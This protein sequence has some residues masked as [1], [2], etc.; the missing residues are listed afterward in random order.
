MKL[1]RITL[2]PLLFPIAIV[3]GIVL[4]IRNRFY[5]WGILKSSEFEIP[6]ISV[7]NITVGGTGKT[8]HIEYLI[9]LLK[10]EYQIAALS[11]G[12]KRKTDGFIL[13][14][15]ESTDL[16]IGDE[17]RQIKQK[18]PEVNIAVDANR[19]EGINKLIRLKPE[20]EAILL[21]DA[22]QHRKVNPGLSILLTDYSRPIFK[23]FMLP[24]GNLRDNY[25]EKKRADV[26]IVTKCPKDLNSKKQNQI[27]ERLKL[28]PS[29]SIFFSTF[30]YGELIPVFSD[31]EKSNSITSKDIEILMVSGIANPTPLKEHILENISENIRVL[32][33][34]DHYSFKPSDFKHI[35]QTFNKI[36]SDDKMIITTEKDAMRLQKFSNIAGKLK[37]RIFYIPIHIEFLNQQ[38]EAFNKQIIEYVRKN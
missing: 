13:S 7:G 19:T 22:F 18:Y 37:N 35:E 34:S 4:F 12:Y 38:S 36:S 15:R 29:Q 16:E 8:P 27:T 9:K 17:P 1:L 2:S 23:D 10:S 31:S 11:R 20:I 33:Y 14:T 3:Y 28:K 21:D 24:L 6:I 26:I 5:D 30:K 25:L 32:E